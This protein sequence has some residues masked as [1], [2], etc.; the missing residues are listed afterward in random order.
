MKRYIPGRDSNRVFF[1]QQQQSCALP[2][3]LQKPSC[4]RKWDFFFIFPQPSDQYWSTL[5]FDQKFIGQDKFGRKT[6]EADHLRF[7]EQKDV[8]RS[9]SKF[10]WK[11]HLW[12]R[13]VLSNSCGDIFDM[14]KWL[15]AN[16]VTSRELAKIITRNIY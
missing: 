12:F 3:E 8:L 2:T 9:L 1:H 4:S 15:L 14:K 5:V 13:L 10:F 7:L 6:I 16:E 11:S